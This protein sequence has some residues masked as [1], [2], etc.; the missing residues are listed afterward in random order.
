M[1]SVLL[2][3]AA[4]LGLA[5]APAAE[6]PDKPAEAAPLIRLAVTPGQVQPRA[7]KYTLLPDPLDLTPGNAA[8]LW[9]RAA[10][11]AHDNP[12]KL[13]DREYDWG[14]SEK[15]PLKDLPKDEVKELLAAYAPALK[16]ADQA[17]RRDHCDW[18]TPPLTFQNF[19]E[20]VLLEEIQQCRKLANLLSIR[21]R[22]ELSEGRFDDALYTLQTGLAMAR[23]IGEGDNLIWNL[24]GTAVAAV[25]LGRVEELV[26]QPGAPI[27]YW[28]LTDLPSPLLNPRRAMR[29][30]LQTVYRSFPPLRELRQNEKKLS[31]EQVNK[32]IADLFTALSQVSGGDLP[33]WQ[34]RLG[35]AALAL[36]VHPEA[37]KYLTAHG[38][39]AEEVE[40]MPVPEAVLLYY[41]DEYDRAVDDVLKWTD[42]PPWQAKAGLDQVLKEVQ[43]PGAVNANPILVLILPAVVKVYQA[44]VRTERQVAALRCAEAL[45]LYATGHDGKPPEK[46]DGV[47]LP[48]PPDPYTGEGFG[49]YYKVGA[50]GTAVLDVPPPPGMPALLGRRFELAPPRPGGEK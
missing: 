44:H 7:L 19:Q 36:A 21:C 8:P 47:G 17:A 49:K 37:K 50:D 9:F 12:R 45:R 35:A 1:R 23:H 18:E 33:D 31:P 4:L 22:L 24:V 2:G 34:K 13:A 46:L 32:L 16:L 30:E 5:A 41:L 6:P 39:T 10:H 42:V 3:A 43:P 29:T 15:T 26:Q 27:L 14:S 28:A 25:M 40:A 11:T 48:L 20:V 38:R